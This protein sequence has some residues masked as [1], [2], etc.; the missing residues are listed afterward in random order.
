MLK[1]QQQQ[2]QQQWRR[3]RGCGHDAQQQRACLHVGCALCCLQPAGFRYMPAGFRHS[4]SSTARL[5]SLCALCAGIVRMRTTQQQRICYSAHVA[6]SKLLCTG[7]VSDK[8]C[9]P[10]AYCCTALLA[11][12]YGIGSEEDPG[13]EVLTGE[14]ITQLV[15]RIY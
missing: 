7:L 10:G 3:T 12:L 14:G 9:I 8:R 11:G 13:P 5:C 6:C 4:S 1:L 15:A 2:Q